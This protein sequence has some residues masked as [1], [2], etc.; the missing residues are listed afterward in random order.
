MAAHRVEVERLLTEIYGYQFERHA[1]L[2]QM[3]NNHG[4]EP[5]R[6]HLMI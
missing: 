4:R 6:V 1:S 5:G 2:R 3:A